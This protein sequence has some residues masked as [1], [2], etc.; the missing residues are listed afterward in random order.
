MTL[1]SGVR[2]GPYEIQSALGSGGM[3]E[4][5]RARDTRLGRT[6]AVKVLIAAEVFNLLNTANLVQYSGNF[7]NPATFGQASGGFGQVFGSVNF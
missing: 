4:V 7:A 5:Y 3:G 1:A 6:V 2:I